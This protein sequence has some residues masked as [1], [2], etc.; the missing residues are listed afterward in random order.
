M[1]ETLCAA[2]EPE[3]ETKGRPRDVDSLGKALALRFVLVSFRAD[4]LGRSRYAVAVFSDPHPVLV[5]Q[6]APEVAGE[7]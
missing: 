2:P 1:L 3:E 5:D 4:L 6:L 7:P